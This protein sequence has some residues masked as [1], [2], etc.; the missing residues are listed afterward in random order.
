MHVVV[1][2]A[3][4]GGLSAAA[5]LRGAGHEV[6][7]VEREPI[8]G[9]RAGV[10]RSDGFVLDNGPTVLTMPDLLENTFQAVGAD[11]ADFVTI[12]P[13]DP[14]YRA[15]YTDGSELL[16]RHGRDAM[17]E[18]VR[19]FAGPKE[20][21]AFGRFSGWLEQLYTHE[22]IRCNRSSSKND[23]TFLPS[24]PN[25]PSR[26]SASPSRQG[27]TRS[28]GESRLVSMNERISWV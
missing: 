5:H 13:V 6:T 19:G 18:E 21:E 1:I 9:G 20:A 2:G 22:K 17:T 14:M 24:L 4:L 25:P 8:P 28:S 10:I 26:T 15:C 7:L 23:A 27:F 3:G 16:V 11:M 12:K